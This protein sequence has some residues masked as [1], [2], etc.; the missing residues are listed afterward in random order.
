MFCI[1][2]ALLFCYFICI[3]S[4]L[5]CQLFMC[6]FGAMQRITK[7]MEIAKNVHVSSHN[8]LMDVFSTKDST[9]LTWCPPVVYKRHAAMCNMEM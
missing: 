2:H 4:I 7:W 3:Y 1:S 9:Q 8:P 5:H 6:N